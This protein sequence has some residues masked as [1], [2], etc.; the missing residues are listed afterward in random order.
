MA[1]RALPWPAADAG[2]AADRSR[3]PARGHGGAERPANSPATGIEIDS[4]SGGQAAGHGQTRRSDPL[5][6]TSRRTAGPPCAGTNNG[7]RKRQNCDAGGVNV[8][9]GT[10]APPRKMLLAARAIT[11]DTV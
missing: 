8:E 10:I 7:N 4:Y 2:G 3:R 1:P 6:G 11:S 5:G 9:R